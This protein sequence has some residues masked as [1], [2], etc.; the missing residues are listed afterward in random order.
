M[1][2][3]ALKD[4]S[5]SRPFCLSNAGVNKNINWLLSSLLVPGI[6][7]TGSVMRLKRHL[8]GTKPPLMLFAT[9]VL[10]LLKFKTSAV[11]KVRSLSYQCCLCFAASHER[12]KKE[13]EI[14]LD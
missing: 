1:S 4:L 12:F 5:H 13:L 9:A 8:N 3:M 10:F 7:H 2:V 6:V 14:V 11:R